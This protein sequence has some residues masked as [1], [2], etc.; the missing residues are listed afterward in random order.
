[1]AK[2]DSTSLNNA[3]DKTAVDVRLVTK[4]C[5]ELKPEQYEIVL[6]FLSSMV[7]GN[8]IEWRIID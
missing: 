5:R 6:G 7:V 3:Q 2:T 1:M 4:L 8:Q